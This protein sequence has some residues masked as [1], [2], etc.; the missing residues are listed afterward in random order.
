MFTNPDYP[1]SNPMVALIDFSRMAYGCAVKGI[2]SHQMDL[3]LTH[4][5]KIRKLTLRAIMEMKKK[6][7]PKPKPKPGGGGYGRYH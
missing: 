6:P 4:A 2:M 3:V 5:V 1:Y 7:K